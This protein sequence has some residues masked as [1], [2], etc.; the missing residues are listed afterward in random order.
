MATVNTNPSVQPKYVLK[1]MLID[2]S[3]QMTDAE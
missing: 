1:Y 3:F 2:F